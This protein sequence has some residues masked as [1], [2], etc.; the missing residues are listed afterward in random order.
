ML[1]TTPTI[2]PHLSS[3]RWGIECYFFAQKTTFWY[4]LDQ[5]HVL[6]PVI[7]HDKTAQNILQ[8]LSDN[9]LSIIESSLCTYRS[10]LVELNQFTNSSHL[11]S[12]QFHFNNQDQTLHCVYENLPITLTYALY[13]ASGFPFSIH[14]FGKKI[15]LMDGD[16]RQ[17]YPTLAVQL[18]DHP[19]VRLKLLLS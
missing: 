5:Y 1:M 11:S 2:K 10:V 19:F 8:Q 16:M 15:D 6:S 7:Y 9:D 14:V 18:K 13:P 3:K 12:C 4:F 17:F